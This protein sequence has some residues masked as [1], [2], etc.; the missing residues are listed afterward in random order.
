MDAAAITIAVLL[1]LLMLIIVITHWGLLGDGSPKE[2]VPYID[3]RASLKTFDVVAFRG[4]GPISS[5]I[6][7]AE[8]LFR[9]GGHTDEYTHVGLIIR[10]G[11]LPIRSPLRDPERVYIFESTLGG[12]LGDQVQSVDGAA[13]AGAQLRDLDTVVA[14]YDRRRGNSLDW[15]SLHDYYRPNT[16]ES[17]VAHIL[18]RHGRSRVGAFGRGLHRLPAVCGPTALHARPFLYQSCA[19]LVANVMKDI[20]VLPPTVEPART[21]PADWSQKGGRLGMLYRP[22]LR[23]RA[24]RFTGCT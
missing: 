1:V 23:F 4:K 11:D 6:K 22:A 14:M 5:L 7:Q 19:E 9:I 3:I 17:V 18:S 12:W 24:T 8:G 21:A 2:G 13:Y 16:I 15:L 20:G 10:G